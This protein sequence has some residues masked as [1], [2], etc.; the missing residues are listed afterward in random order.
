MSACVTLQAAPLGSLSSEELQMAAKLGQLGVFLTSMLTH[1]PAGTVVPVSPAAGLVNSEQQS[2]GPTL[3]ALTLTLTL[4]LTLRQTQG[5]LSSG[6]QLSTN[7]SPS[8]VEAAVEAPIQEPL[9]SE[10]EQLYH[11][12][13]HAHPTDTGTFFVGRDFLSNDL[14]HITN[15]PAAASAVLTRHKKD[16]RQGL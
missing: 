16:R 10:S 9:A 11:M 4:T 12:P 6:P 1:L 15:C 3:G 14:L 13:C 8:G 7:R 5:P 2:A